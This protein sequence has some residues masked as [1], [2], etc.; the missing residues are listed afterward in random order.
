MAGKVSM[1]VMFHLP[2]KK[3]RDQK[4]KNKKKEK[5]EKEMEVKIKSTMAAIS[6]WEKRVKPKQYFFLLLLRWI[7]F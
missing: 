2:Y 5:K 7:F 3:G 6:C 1:V 4:K